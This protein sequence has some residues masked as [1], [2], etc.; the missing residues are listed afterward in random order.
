VAA[1]DSTSAP[2]PGKLGYW[3]DYARTMRDLLRLG[4]GARKHAARYSVVLIND[5]AEELSIIELTSSAGVL[6]RGARLLPHSVQTVALT[7]DARAASAAESLTLAWHGAAGAMRQMQ[8]SIHA[9]VPE[10]ALQAVRADA[11]QR[12]CIALEFG[13]QGSVRS[14]WGVVDDRQVQTWPDQTG[15]Y[16]AA[17]TAD[18]TPAPVPTPAGEPLRPRR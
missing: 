6:L 5:S 11:Q 13:A 10:S 9:H 18:R 4:T 2:V 3:L 7:G 17:F 15:R 8:I 16:D 14:S 12:L 1:D